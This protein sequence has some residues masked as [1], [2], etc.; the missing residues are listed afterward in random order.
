MP[1]AMRRSVA[2]MIDKGMT[3]RQIYEDLLKTHGPDLVKPH[4]LP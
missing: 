1:N 3:D 2:E 4:L